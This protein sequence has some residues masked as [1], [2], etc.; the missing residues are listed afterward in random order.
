MISIAGD[1]GIENADA[2][3]EYCGKT[4]ITLECLGLGCGGI[5]TA[6]VGLAVACGGSTGIDADGNDTIGLVVAVPGGGGC[7]VID[8]GGR[9]TCGPVLVLVVADG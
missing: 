3:G 8:A 9:V 7:T 4:A 2:E 1:I 5:A 6:T